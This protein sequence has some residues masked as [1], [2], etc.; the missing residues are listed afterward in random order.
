[1]SV[2]IVNTFVK[3]SIN[4]F[5]LVFQ[6]IINNINTVLLDLYPFKKLFSVANLRN[7]V[8]KKFGGKNFDKML[9]N[10]TLYSTTV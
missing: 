6:I 9:F 8:S 1:M 5:T 2:Y 3:Q 10:I 4:L 7:I